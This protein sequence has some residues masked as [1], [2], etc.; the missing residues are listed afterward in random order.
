MS[1]RV[2]LLRTDWQRRQ[3]DLRQRK[4]W[5]LDETGV[6]L[7]LA[8]MFGRAYG[9]QRANGN[10]PKN[11]GQSITVL[12]AMNRDGRM[13]TLEVRGATDELVMLAFIREILAPVIERGD[14]V[15][16]DNLTSH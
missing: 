12:G 16:M 14:T 8:R 11:Y 13:A 1:E 15:V 7:S 5:F 2:R 6:N 4:I 3:A 9:G 10:V